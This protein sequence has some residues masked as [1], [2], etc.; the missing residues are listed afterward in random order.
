MHDQEK[1]DGIAYHNLESE[2]HPKF[3]NHSIYD[4]YDIA[5]ITLV[6]RIEFSSKIRTICLPQPNAE[7]PGRYA[8]VAGWCVIFLDSFSFKITKNNKN[9]LQGTV[10]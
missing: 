6:E 9:Q 2:L 3:I 4:D 5:V 8:I 10:G 7:Y 1:Q